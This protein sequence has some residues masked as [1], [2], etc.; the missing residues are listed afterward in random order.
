MGSTLGQQG[1]RERMCMPATQLCSSLALNGN[2]P[3]HAGHEGH[4]RA[5]GGSAAPRR[6][7]AGQVA[8]PPQQRGGGCAGRRQGA[9]SQGRGGRQGVRAARAQVESCFARVGRPPLCCA[10]RC[11]T[12]SPPTCAHPCLTC[13]QRGRQ[14]CHGAGGDCGARGRGCGGR[15]GPAGCPKQPRGVAGGARA[16]PRPG[17]GQGAGGACVAA[18]MELLLLLQRCRRLHVTTR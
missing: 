11:I 1:G 14:D 5:G 4:R 17:A 15:Q 10:R 3:T 13:L 2:P 16:P 18:W 8:T 12:A 6:P 9:G 7:P